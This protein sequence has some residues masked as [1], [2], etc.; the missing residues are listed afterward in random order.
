MISRLIHFAVYRPY[1]TLL[2]TVVAC[3]VGWYSVEQLPIDA[4]PDITNVQVQV[5]TVVEGLAPEE[6][7]R[8][9]TFPLETAMSGIRDVTLVRSIT[10]FGLS[11]LT[12]IFADGVD[13]YRARQLVAERV[14]AARSRLPTDL[15]PQLGPI[16][17]GLG[18]IFHYSVEAEK[19]EM[20]EART[21][22]LMELRAIQEWH[23]KPRLLTV[24]GVAEVNTTGGWEKQFH[25]QP[26]PAA[27]AGYGI[28]F[29][30]IEEALQRTNKNAGGGYVQQ[31]GEQFLVQAAGLL[32]SVDEIRNVPVKSL[33]TFK[34]VTIGDIAEVGLGKE[35]R[36]GAA[37]VRG[38]EAV[39]GTVLMLMGEN[40]RTVSVRVADRVK[41]IERTLPPGVKIVT[42]YDRSELVNATL[43][44]VLHN[45]LF[46]ATL[47]IVVLLLLLGNVR[48][49][50]I[51]SIT[52]PVSLLITFAVMKRLGISGN[53]MSLGA[54][55]FGIIVDGAVIVIDN[56]VRVVHD[57]AKALG[58]AL[59]RKEVRSAVYDAS[60]EIRKAAGFG[61]LIIAVVFLP[62]FALVGIE[63]K[64]FVPMAATFTIALIAALCLSFTTMPALAGVFLRGD[65]TDREPFLM[66]WVHKLYMPTL[67]LALKHRSVTVGVGV[68]MIA[69]GG[70]LF[71]RLGGE[72][73]PKLD[74]GS[75]AVQF[76]RPVNISLDQ[77]VALQE[78]S[79]ALLAEFPEVSG[80]FSRIG[81]AEIATDP[82]GVNLA[83]TYV[84]LESTEKWPAVGAAPR[85]KEMLVRD[86]AARL[87]AEIPGQRFL[88]SQPIEMRFNELLEGT[89]AAISVKIFGDD[90]NQLVS[91]AKQVSGVIAKVP[92]AGD[93]EAELRG[94]SPLLRVEPKEAMVNRLGLA[95]REILDTVGIALG[96]KET[97]YLYQGVMRFPI[98]IRLGEEDRRDLDA[99]RK[100]PVGTPSNAIV[101]L[102]EISTVK[103][104]ET[105]SAV[106]RE[107]SKRRAAVLVNP[108]GRDTEGFVLEAQRAVNAAVKLPPGYFIEWGGNFKN[109]QE[110]RARL[111][112]LTPL[113]LLLVLLMIYTAFRSVVETM[114][115][116]SGVPLALVG[117]VMG[118][119]GNDLPF[120]ISAGV[121]FIAL[122][123]IAVLNGVVLINCFNDLRRHGIRGKD[124][125]RQGAALR[126][127]PVLMTA[128]VDIFGFLPMMLSTGVG[129][130]VQRPLASVVIGGIG[131]TT[132]LTLVVLPAL[133][134]LFERWTSST[135][136]EDVE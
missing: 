36:T 87:E 64:M 95:N 4:V 54:L 15:Q 3:G 57:R 80:V 94:T 77:S 119:M 58:R 67:D 102:S 19:V 24:E 92:G 106:N 135:E 124:G 120:S 136:P 96:G 118:L 47:V 90:M 10:R 17:T 63:G 79:E 100:L 112:V 44:T 22:Q 101:P 117:G 69:L 70:I 105:F 33:E 6:I 93:V 11:Q 1:L 55:D 66:R 8:S 45:L 65:T 48:A 52:I 13:I 76:I 97:G 131:S 123:G 133:F 43:D 81:T 116:F 18:E 25:I 111:S 26:K 132:I 23:V 28:H 9:V 82:M 14:Q 130:E 12:I 39:L 89:R 41:E 98:V 72:F 83:D 32:K 37:L 73:L 107:Q 5:N 88:F 61:E 27:M 84:M 56:C 59:T 42:L 125:I 60:V 35:L 62:I 29:D 128:L 21:K 114:I 7:E 129:A 109:L 38:K 78:K 2:L 104:V 30:D 134:S 103:F 20:G 53:L 126:L 86:M 46:G 74:E 110:A 99:I 113:A 16:S 127:R 122:C 85:T 108:R 34:V 75:L 71:A 50:V 121:G 51:T 68:A 40:S 115:I 49:A 91:L 31:T